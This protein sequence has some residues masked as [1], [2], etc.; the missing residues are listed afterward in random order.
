MGATGVKAM[1]KYVDEIEPR[2][3]TVN[4]YVLSPA[5][6]WSPGNMYLNQL[7]ANWP[8]NLQFL[9]RRLNFNQI[10]FEN[11]INMCSNFNKYVFEIS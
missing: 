2:L 5:Q 8:S 11:S 10:E 1:S 3:S 4:F 6:T 9:V 7:I